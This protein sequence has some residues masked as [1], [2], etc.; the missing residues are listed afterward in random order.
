MLAILSSSLW[1]Q[2][3]CQ[4]GG[5]VDGWMDGYL[6]YTGPWFGNYVQAWTILVLSPSI[7]ANFLLI[8]RKHVNK[9]FGLQDIIGNACYH[10]HHTKLRQNKQ[11]APV[12]FF[13][14]TLPTVSCIWVVNLLLCVYIDNV[15]DFKWMSTFAYF[16]GSF[17]YYVW[18]AAYL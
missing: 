15:L 11:K 4:E 8:V 13:L 14:T 16:F 9:R 1:A 10:G 3:D 7:W 2:M 18:F 5:S 6:P 17:T 12:W